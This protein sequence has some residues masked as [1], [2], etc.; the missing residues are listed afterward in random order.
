[1][2][3]RTGMTTTA[4]HV[5]VA[6][7]L[8]PVTVLGPGRRVALWVQGCALACEGCSALDTW[9]PADGAL[10]PVDALVDALDDTIAADDLDGLTLTGGEPT[11]QAEALTS[12]IAGLRSRRP[13]LDVLL[14]TGRTLAAARAVAQE[15]AAA[16]TCVVA[17]PY[18]PELATP[19][20]RLVATANQELL[21]QPG[22]SARYDAWL[23]DAAGPR[24]Q[25]MAEG[26]ALYLVG[27]PGPG[28]L[29]RFRERL[30]DRGVI[31][32]GVSW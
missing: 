21:V 6:R 4:T 32:E 30:A 16:A 20:H 18:R 26:G 11:D 12:V 13:G 15:L 7:V 10:W 3:G 29:D 27:M 22:A 17:G 19:T 31:V 25:V 8:A 1:M 9:D 5:N 24:L 14:F 28:D 2:D 23:A